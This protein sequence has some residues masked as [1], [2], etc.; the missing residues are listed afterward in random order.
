MTGMRFLFVLAMLGANGAI[1]AEDQSQSEA[2][3]LRQRAED[4]ARAASQRFTEILD[5]G[6]QTQPSATQADGKGSPTPY[7]RVVDWLARSSKS[8]DD[9]VIAEL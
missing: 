5:T 9:I 6:K 4:L 7:A 8:Y 1:A 3:A 2:P